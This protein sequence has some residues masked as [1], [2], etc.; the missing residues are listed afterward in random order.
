VA[1]GEAAFIISEEGQIQRVITNLVLNARDAMR[2]GGSVFLRVL[3]VPG[4]AGVDSGSARVVLEV[5]DTGSG[6]SDEVKERLFE[7]FFTTK[8]AAGTGLGL[9]SVRDWWSA[10]AVA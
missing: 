8:G 9:A 7:P 3:R 10:R 5:E 6:M 4:A 2:E 1:A